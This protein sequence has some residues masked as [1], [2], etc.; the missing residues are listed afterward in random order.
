MELC[1][2][3]KAQD[4]DASKGKKSQSEPGM[5]DIHTED[6]DEEEKA[7]EKGSHA[8]DNVQDMTPVEHRATPGTLE[9]KPDAQLPESD[10]TH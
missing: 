5:E 10:M 6:E 2:V 3:L 9:E 1:S 7:E 8:R 4:E